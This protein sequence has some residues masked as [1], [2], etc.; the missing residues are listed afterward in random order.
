MFIQIFSTKTMSVK[1]GE[2]EAN[3]G[4]A[5]IDGLH[6]TSL[7]TI[8]DET[9]IVIGYHWLSCAQ[10][11]HACTFPLLIIKYGGQR[12]YTQSIHWYA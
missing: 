3:F 12:H 6:M 11:V 9:R 2:C 4:T 1:P 8:F 5:I 7:T 10:R